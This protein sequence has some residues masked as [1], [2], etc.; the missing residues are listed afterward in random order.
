VP[1]F[2]QL[3]NQIAPD[4]LDQQLTQVHITPRGD[5]RIG[6]VVRQIDR[7]VINRLTL[8]HHENSHAANIARRQAS[9]S[10]RDSFHQKP[11]P[12]KIASPDIQR[13]G[14]VYGQP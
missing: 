14:A 10:T 4:T 3:R 13:P 8:P 6:I 12:H 2:Q 1:S 9:Q 7:D 11:P 5:A